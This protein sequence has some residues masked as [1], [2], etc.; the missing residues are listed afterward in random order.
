M[1]FYVI[2][3]YSHSGFKHLKKIQIFLVKTDT[4]SQGVKQVKAEV[5]W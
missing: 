1:N 2:Q 3:F 4:K 5:L